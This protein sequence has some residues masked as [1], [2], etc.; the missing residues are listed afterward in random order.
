MLLSY[1]RLLSRSAAEAAVVGFWLYVERNA[2]T[3]KGMRG[4]RVIAAGA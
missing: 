4:H 3:W 1:V 2:W